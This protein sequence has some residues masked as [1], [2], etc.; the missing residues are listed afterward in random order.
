MHG[1]IF[2][3]AN[4]AGKLPQGTISNPLKRRSVL[5]VHFRA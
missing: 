2:D 4:V 3:D 5:Q 1:S